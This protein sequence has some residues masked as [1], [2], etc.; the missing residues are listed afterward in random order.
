MSKKSKAK[1]DKKKRRERRVR[2]ERNVRRGLP[3]PRSDE[4]VGDLDLVAALEEL[5]EEVHF[6]RI[7]RRIVRTTGK[8]TFAS[9][10]ES[11]AELEKLSADGSVALVGT[12]ERPDAR[13]DAQDLAFLAADPANAEYM[14]ELVAQALELDPDCVDAAARRAMREAPDMPGTVVALE[15]VVA[16]AERALG[17]PDF[18]TANRGTLWDDVMARPYL[19]ARRSLAE[20]LHASGRMAEAATHFAALVDLAPDSPL[21][22][23]DFALG[24][25]LERGELERA[26]ELIALSDR[27]GSPTARWASA[28]ERW[29]AGDRTR[30]ADLA[31]VARE[32]D[33]L[34]ERELLVAGSIERGRSRGSPDDAYEFSTRGTQAA[35]IALRIGAAWRAHPDALAW[36]AGGAGATTPEEREAA[37]ATFARPVSAL[38]TIGEEDFDRD[39][40]DYPGRFRLSAS[41]VP[42]LL[43]MATDPVMHEL[44]D[45]DPRAWAALHAWRALGTLAAPEAVAPLLELAIRSPADGLLHEDLPQVFSRIG[46]AALAPLIAVLAD[47]ERES[48]ACQVASELLADV[49]AGDPDR[50]ARALAALAQLLERCEE[51]DP[52]VNGWVISTLVELRAVELAPEI[53]SAFELDLVDETIAGDWRSVAKE[54]GV[55]RRTR[56]RG[57]RGSGDAD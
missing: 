33:P 56:S 34:V 29:L 52:E 21:G 42:A 12:P 51:N 45:D 57:S 37:C 3:E 20:A 30:A 28:L 9:R 15:A 27:S 18:L 14:D 39:W 22:V 1:L 6:E 41:D 23:A 26:R 50:R 35:F 32:D 19:R 40:I 25:A 10:A 48:S 46:E 38:L 17:G 47:H 36:L 31:R 7:Q 4:F 16:R 54:L 13:E 11:L 2:L 53:R 5:P 43:R 55:P 24:F 8:R 49:A 44:D